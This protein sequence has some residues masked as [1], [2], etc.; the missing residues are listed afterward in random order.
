VTPTIGGRLL[1]PAPQICQFSLFAVLKSTAVCVCYFYRCGWT[2]LRRCFSLWVLVSVFC[3][4]THLTTSTTITYTSKW[5]S[6]VQVGLPTAAQ[7]PSPPAHPAAHFIPVLRG[8][9]GGSLSRL[10]CRAA[11]TH[12]TAQSRM[13]STVTWDVTWCVSEK[14]RRFGGIQSPETRGSK[15]K[16]SKK[17]QAQAVSFLNYSSTLED[18]GDMSLRIISYR[19]RSLPQH[20]ALGANEKGGGGLLTL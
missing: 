9:V 13:N 1:Q 4:P 7:G 14:T 12:K 8:R 3:W 15:S 11:V 17:Q 20:L 6:S 10:A 2:Q 19:L 18:G 5:P 16:P